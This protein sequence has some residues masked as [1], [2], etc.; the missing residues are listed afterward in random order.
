MQNDIRAFGIAGGGWKATVLKAEVW[1]ETAMEGGR[2]FMAAWRKQDVAF[3]TCH[4]LGKN[5]HRQ[6]NIGEWQQRSST[7]VREFDQWPNEYV[8][9]LPFFS[10][11]GEYVVQFS[12]PDGTFL[13]CDHGSDVCVC[14]VTHISRV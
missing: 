7:V 9:L 14:M 4:V 1:V 3:T 13:P 11:Y 8:P 10:L 5:M 6:Y 12:L 2:R